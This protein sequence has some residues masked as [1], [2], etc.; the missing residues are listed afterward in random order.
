MA[1]M[2]PGAPDRPSGTGLRVGLVGAGFIGETHLAA[3]KSEGIDVVVFDVDPARSSSLAETFGATVAPTIE[4][5]LAATDA[6]DICTPTHLHASVAIAAASARRHVIC[7]KPL[8]RTL[9]DGEAMLAAARHAG[10]RLLVGQVVR[11]FPEY[12]AARQAVMAGAIGDPAVLRLTRA[13]SR[14]RQPADHW[15]FDHARSG[16]IILDLM[17][18]DL[19]YARWVAGEVVSVTCRSAAFE[20]PDAGVDHAVAILRHAS[21]AISHVSAS[22]AYAPPTF[23]TAF[24]IAGSRGLIEQDSDGTA[25]VE[26]SLQDGGASGRT[27]SLAEGAL[28]GDPFRLELAE[29]ARAI[30]ANVEPRTDGG[31]ALKTLRLALAAD[32]SAR[33]FGQTIRL[34]PGAGS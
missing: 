32:E 2:R 19:D 8:A 11:F 24:E 15:F 13:S 23:R 21:G 18:H 5:L 4:A 6:V 30:E 28:S 20:R 22:W 27:T 10:V 16:G 33:S 17:I 34:A 3:W 14:P 26:R 7:E 9:A 1:I 29:F 31:D 12:A 25:P